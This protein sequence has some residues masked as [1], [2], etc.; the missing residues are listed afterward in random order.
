MGS[1]P[2][3]S[4]LTADRKEILGLLARDAFE[5]RTL[6]GNN[7]DH[8]MDSPTAENGSLDLC[9]PPAI[10]SSAENM[11]SE[12]GKYHK[13]RNGP[14]FLILILV[15]VSSQIYGQTGFQDLNFEAATNMPSTGPTLVA[16]SN[17][18][19][20]W[21]VYQAYF[22][23]GPSTQV[24]YGGISAG[25]A[26]VTLISISSAY[27]NDVIAGNYTATLDGGE[28]NMAPGSAGIAQT[29]VIPPST[30][31]LFFLASGDVNGFLTV[32]VGGQNI[33]YIPLE[34][35]PNNSEL[36]GA[37][38]SGFAGLTEQL[39]FT[40]TPTASDNFPVVFLD[41]IQFS[42]QSIPEPQTWTMLLCGAT[43]LGLSRWKRT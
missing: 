35:G 9:Q 29:G 40:E 32:A 24:F 11:K 26:L 4:H 25:S 20:G 42:S 23:T 36:Y 12:S 6:C 21:T 16:V 27:S 38:I 43:L 28:G 5:F 37:D 19:P 30:S 1:T 31:A 39:A 10:P 8:Q 15:F 17:A 13:T 34:A 33:Q 14:P 7:P 41:N 3:S 2:V 18:F 22:G